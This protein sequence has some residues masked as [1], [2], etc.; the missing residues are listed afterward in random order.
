MQDI[1][2]FIKKHNR[3]YKKNLGRQSRILIERLFSC[4][5]K[6]RESYRAA[7][8]SSSIKKESLSTLPTGNNYH[9]I[10]NN[11]RKTIGELTVFTKQEFALGSRIIRIFSCKEGSASE[12][13]NSLSVEEEKEEQEEEESIYIWLYLADHFSD[14][15]C[16]DTLDV[17]LYFTDLAKIL[18]EIDDEIITSDHAN[19]AFTYA[20]KK[21]N[22]IY[23][24]RREEW[25]KVFIHETFHS[26]GI[27]FALMEEEGYVS[28]IVRPSNASIYRVHI[29]DLRFYE[30]YTETWAEILQVMFYAFR[31][32]TSSALQMKRFETQLFEY[33][34]PFS[35]F[36][37]VK[38][39]DHYSMMYGDLFDKTRAKAYKES[40][41]VFSYYI[42]KS[43]FM[44]YA[45]EFIEWC[46]DNNR[47][48]A[49]F[50]LFFTKTQ[51]NVKSLIGFLRTYCKTAEYLAKIEAMD[52]VVDRKVAFFFETKRN[53]KNEERVDIYETMRMTCTDVM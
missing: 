15:M 21:E 7:I 31:A 30:S 19:T 12:N 51:Q 33:E 35:V 41:P 1:S 32:E 17:Y 4:M 37:C 6:G 45:S 3:G 11:I 26:L 9:L 38:V 28:E 42:I 14:K 39:L 43:V 52:L 2:A 49:P 22:E 34:A 46:M 27:D 23:V 50:F 47:S 20:C 29:T 5:Q 40:T 36:Q 44:N 13:A 25:F 8:A 16:S 53:K 48:S 18:P 24:Y 10:S